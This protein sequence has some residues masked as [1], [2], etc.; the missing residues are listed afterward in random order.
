M[1][2]DTLSNKQRGEEVNMKEGD[3]A[4]ITNKFHAHYGRTGLVGD[5]GT[6]KDGDWLY[7]QFSE[8]EDE[9]LLEL[10]DIELVK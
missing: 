9:V 3:K 5:F 8:R 4:I 10:S 1:M 7:L 2:C 6:D